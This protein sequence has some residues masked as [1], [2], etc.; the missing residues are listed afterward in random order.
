MAEA[1]PSDAPCPSHARARL[2]S[3]MLHGLGRGWVG[4]PGGNRTCNLDLGNARAAAGCHVAPVN[5]IACERRGTPS[6]QESAHELGA[7]RSPPSPVVTVPSV[8]TCAKDQPHAVRK[9]GHRREEQA[10]RVTFKLLCE[11]RIPSE[12][13]RCDP[14][15]G[16]STPR[17]DHAAQHPLSWRPGPQLC[18]PRM[19]SSVNLIS[20]VSELVELFTP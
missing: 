5:A 20:D 12:Q 1:L 17:D 14:P 19:E 11:G 9:F 4:T 18:N 3:T 10:Q 8:G 6:R 16:C 7:A 13:W 15:W 2:D